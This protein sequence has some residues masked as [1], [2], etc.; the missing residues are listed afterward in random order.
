MSNRS[1]QSGL[2]GH[3]HVCAYDYDPYF[4]Q[5]TLVNGCKD[6]GGIHIDG[7]IGSHGCGSFRWRVMLS[8]IALYCFFITK[9]I[10][11]KRLKHTKKRER[12]FYEWQC[13]RLFIIFDRLEWDRQRDQRARKRQAKE[14]TRHTRKDTDCY[15][16]RISRCHCYSDL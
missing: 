8:Q 5:V 7:G 13:L 16:M 12:H 14:C 4:I 2:L 15:T 6:G 11:S 1:G 9:L 3:Q 10:K